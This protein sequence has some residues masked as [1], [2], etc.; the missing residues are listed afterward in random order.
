[1]ILFIYSQDTQRERQRDIGRGRRS[2]IHAGSL[3]WDSI[4]GLPGSCPEPK[5]DAQPLSHPGVPSPTIIRTTLIKLALLD[6][7]WHSKN[8]Y[9]F[10]VPRFIL[11]DVTVRPS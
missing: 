9:G 4:L 8:R 6:F 10:P 7:L 3:M 1:M 5:A 2:R 11:A